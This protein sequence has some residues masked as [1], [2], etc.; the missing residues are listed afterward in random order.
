MIFAALG[1][2][3]AWGIVDGVM[4]VL[5]NVF[6]RSRYT[7]VISSIRSTVDKNA[8]LAVIE[9]ELEPI[10][11]VLD[12]KERKRIYAEVLKSA[13]KASPQEALVRNDDVFGAFS[14]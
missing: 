7:R 9:E 14:C 10:K 13:S 3:T 8:A 12:E 5:T 11:W 2:N 6:E 1:C 4:Y